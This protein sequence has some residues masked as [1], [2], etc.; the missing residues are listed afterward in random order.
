LR[1]ALE[2]SRREHVPRRDAC[3]LG[4]VSRGGFSTSVSSFSTP[5]LICFPPTIAVALDLL[6]RDF[7]Q[8]DDRRAELRE[9]LDELDGGGCSPLKIVSPS[10]QRNGSLPNVSARLEDRVARPALLD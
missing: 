4:A 2:D 9:C 1:E 3:R 10:R 6:G 7:L 8:T 5:S